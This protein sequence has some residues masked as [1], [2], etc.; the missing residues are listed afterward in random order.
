[1]NSRGRNSSAVAGAPPHPNSYVVPGMRLIAGEYPFTGHSGTAHLKLRAFL[2]SGITFFLDLTEDHE[3]D[4]YEPALRD[5][6]ELRGAV[7]E[8]VRLPI[9]DMGVTSRTTM[10]K[11]LDT[12][13]GALEAGHVVYV[14]CWGGVGRTGTVVGCH[15][16]R[17]GL[18][19]DAA[20]AQVAALFAT[21]SPE[22]IRQHPWGSPQTAEQRRFVLEWTEGDA[23]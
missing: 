9:P 13:D 21:M 15:Q 3:L 2:D 4:P 23:T 22:K 18:S 5:E 19:G 10:A 6:A 17:G 8:Y 1:M 11:I 20:L 12:I 7:L 16:V 14:H